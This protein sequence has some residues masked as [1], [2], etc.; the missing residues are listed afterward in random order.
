MVYDPYSYSKEKW[1]DF[2]NYESYVSKLP[3]F[4]RWEEIEEIEGM[5]GTE[6][7]NTTGKTHDEIIN[8]IT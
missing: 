6:I 2:R 1:V 8:E 4:M 5:E 7:D 3:N